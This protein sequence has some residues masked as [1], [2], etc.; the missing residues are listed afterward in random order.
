MIY[1]Q[2]EAKRRKFRFLFCNIGVRKVR[3]SVQQLVLLVVL[4]S[5]K[6]TGNI[7]S[8][9]SLHTLSMNIM[10]KQTKNN[11]AKKSNK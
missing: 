2:A 3:Y 5:S 7:N 4:V 6:L 11:L 8:N 9:K 1:Q 10:K